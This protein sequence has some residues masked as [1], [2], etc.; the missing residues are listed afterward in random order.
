ML[1]VALFVFNSFLKSDPKIADMSRIL[2][3]ALYDYFFA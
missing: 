2:F 1:K 3:V